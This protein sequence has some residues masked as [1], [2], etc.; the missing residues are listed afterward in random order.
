MFSEIVHLLLGGASA[1]EQ[2]GLSPAGMVVVETDGAIEQ[3]DFLKSAYEGA[4]ET[5]LHVTRDSFDDAL[6]L[7][8]VAARQIGPL[9]LSETCRRCPVSAV[10]GGGLY[11]HRYREGNGFANPSVYCRDLLRLITHIK[12]T[13][14]ADLA[15]RA[16]ARRTRLP[17][18]ARPQRRP[19]GTDQGT[20]MNL[21]EHRISRKV[22]LELASGGGG[23]HAVAQLATAQRSK[24]VLLVRGVLETARTAG[25]PQ[26]TTARRAYDL[27]AAIQRRH[28]RP[29]TPSCVT[30]RWGPGPGTRSPRSGPAVRTRHRPSSRLWLRLRRSGPA[31]R[32]RSTFPRS[33]A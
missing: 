14:E 10:C 22:F 18:Q 28:P 4:P 16:E 5:G 6:L 17:S 33:K 19:V 3:S 11:A 8:S 21:R 32:A 24:H 29:W 31:R 26:A 7:P 12:H 1:T 25:H 23:A 2:V 13:V 27:L 15:A 20:S 9:A 30:L